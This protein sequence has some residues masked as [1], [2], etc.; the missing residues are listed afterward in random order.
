VEDENDNAQVSE[1]FGALDELKRLSNCPNLLL[2]A[3]TPRAGAD[4][5]R[6]S[7]EMEAWP[8]ANWYLGKIKGMSE[9]SF[10][11][12]GRDVHL[13][14][15]LLGYSSAS[16]TFSALL[17]TAIEAKRDRALEELVEVLKA[18][19]GKMPSVEALL[20]S[21]SGKTDR[22]RDIVRIAEEQEIIRV[23]ANGRRKTVELL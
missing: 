22:K 23:R 17:G 16:R 4:R 2:A 10:R 12:E 3:H 18:H 5:A 8:D 20:R 7:G 14:E 6:G 11:A 13:E 15:T 21:M 9:R 19:D 1:F